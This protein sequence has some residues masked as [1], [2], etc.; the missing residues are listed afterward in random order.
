MTSL[1]V[2][3]ILFVGLHLLMSHP[4]R[5]RLVDTAGD[6]GFL[7]V[8][9]FVSLATLAGAIG[10]WMAVGPQHPYFVSPGWYHWVQ[11]V[12][13]IPVVILF[14]GSLFGNPALP[15]PGA[16]VNAM[17]QPRGVFAITRHPMMWAFAFWA[18]LHFIGMASPRNL[19]LM[20]GIAFLALA[21]AWGQDIKKDRM[22]GQAWQTWTM[23]TS[24]VPF[25]RQLAGAKWK[26]ARPRG[27]VVVLALL[28]WALLT[29]T[30]SWFAGVPILFW[31]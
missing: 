18:I 2:A 23:R 19:A 17:R 8:Y 21:G 9:S 5:D 24:F 3:V 11:G 15:A 7:A 30:H 20:G 28:I 10:F 27:P 6:A 29:W 31:R 22:I 14:T 25:G 4:L 13:M 16:Q 12:L 1:W 26:H